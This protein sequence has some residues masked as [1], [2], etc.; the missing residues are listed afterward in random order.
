DTLAGASYLVDP[1]APVGARVRG[2]KVGG[3]PVQ[4]KEIFSLVVNSYRAAGGGNYPFLRQ[5]PRVKLV[6]AQVVDLLVAYFAKVG[7]LHLEASGNWLFAPQ[8][9]LAP[10]PRR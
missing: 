4:P 1:T 3:K 2:L 7:T 10:Q 6:D 9:V 5:A 8:L